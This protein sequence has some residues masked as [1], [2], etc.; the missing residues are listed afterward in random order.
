[1]ITNLYDHFMNSDCVSI[2]FGAKFA[3][4]QTGIIFNNEMDDFGSPNIT[5]GFAVP[6]SPGIYDNNIYD[7]KTNVILFFY[8]RI[9]IS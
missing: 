2:S 4:E 1:M 3:S 7:N 8:F 5:N 6:P 9:Y